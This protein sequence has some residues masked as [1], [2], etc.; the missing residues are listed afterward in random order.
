MLKS[1]RLLLIDCIS[2]RI[3]TKHMFNETVSYGPKKCPKNHQAS[4]HVIFSIRESLN[5]FT[6][7]LNMN[8]QGITDEMTL[9]LFSYLI[10]IG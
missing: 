4:S 6:A 7:I 8:L 5:I 10:S 3:V 1:S 9:L 2:F